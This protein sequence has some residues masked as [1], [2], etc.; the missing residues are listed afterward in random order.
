MKVGPS[1][2]QLQRDV[3]FDDLILRVQQ[4]EGNRIAMANAVEVVVILVIEVADRK[5]RRVVVDVPEDIG[6][7]GRAKGEALC[8]AR[9]ILGPGRP[10]AGASVSDPAIREVDDNVLVG[11]VVRVVEFADVDGHGRLWVKWVNL[12]CQTVR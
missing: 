6:S 5:F 11:G 10:D 2:V 4:R 9:G 1:L 8:N 3:G 12:T 7:Q